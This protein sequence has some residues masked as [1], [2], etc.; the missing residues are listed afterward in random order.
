MSA[1]ESHWAFQPLT[2]PAVPCQNKSSIAGAIDAFLQAK[3]AEAGLGAA[4][5]ADRGTLIR[6]LTLDLVGLPP[7]EQEIEAF[8]EDPSPLAYDHLVDR[9]LASPQF[10]GRWGRYWLDGAAYSDVVGTD[11]DA[12]IIRPL[13]NR[14]LYRDYVVRS[15][16]EDKPFPRFLLEQIAGDELVD[17]RNAPTYSQEIQELLIATGFLRMS[18][19]DTFENE[20]NLPPAQHGVLERTIEIL[21]NNLLGLSLACAKCHDHKYEPLTQQD[22]YRF[23]AIF[24]PAFNPDH[25]RQPA[26]RQLPAM[27]PAE[28]ARIDAHN[29]DVDRRLQ[30]AQASLAQLR[31]PYE[32][33]LREE[34]LAAI[35]E[36]IRADTKVAIETPAEQRSEIQKYLASKF[37]PMLQVAPDEVS[38]R[39]SETDALKSLELDELIK[40]LPASR[41]SWSH[42]QVV[43]DVAPPTPTRLLE[44]GDLASPGELVEPAM[45]E[46]F[47]QS[48]PVTGAGSSSSSGRRLALARNLTDPQSRAGALVLRVQVN[49]IW[50]RL[51]GRGFVAVPDNFGVTSSLPTHPELLEW[52]A[53]TFV[54]D[55]QRLKTFIRRIVLSSAYRQASI[56][57]DPEAERLDPA[58]HLLWKQ[59]LRRLDS[60]AIRDSAL[61]ASGE[62]DLS[63]GGPPLDVEPQPDGS[64][65]VKE[66]GLPARTSP[67]RRTLYL[68]ARR[69]YHPTILSVFDQPNFVSHC[70][71]RQNSAVV[72]QSLTMLNDRFMIDRAASMA[73]SVLQTESDTQTALATAFRRSLGRAPSE[74][75]LAYCQTAYEEEIKW[76]RATSP[77][78]AANARQLAFTTICHTLMNTSEFLYVP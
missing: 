2:T 54:A 71:M 28:K 39:L 58:N 7:S 47:G 34:K 37:E 48:T 6:R 15:L 70:A 46:V 25:W 40:T 55:G 60:D 30:E 32:A 36:V 65:V 77:I 9:L 74:S 59:R 42:W 21:S 3:L 75:E 73:S 5:E 29:A 68:L 64:F 43:F 62:L 10:G 38:A 72:L 35:P 26:Q 67:H 22:Y 14:W 27:S 41:K 1:D 61:A 8:L 66:K 13:E 63:I 49:R 19:D 76:R 11:N 45:F 33:L 31:Q 12:A 18:P 20:L 44:R 78:D 56:H 17:W 24:Q 53:S 16:N 69:N 51:F 4:P 57:S 52:L 50:Q 23:K